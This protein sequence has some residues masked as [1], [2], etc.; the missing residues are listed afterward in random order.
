MVEQECF[1]ADSV[2]AV[3]TQTRLSLLN[4]ARFHTILRIVIHVDCFWVYLCVRVEL[5]Q[6][7]PYKNT[8]WRL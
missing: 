3:E 7:V 1:P 8:T 2:S 6:I 5:R 4:G